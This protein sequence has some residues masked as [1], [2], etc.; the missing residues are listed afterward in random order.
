MSIAAPRTSMATAADL[1]ALSEDLRAEVVGGEIVQKA[2]PSFEHGDAQSALAALLK[3]PFQRGRGGPGGWWIAPEV[4]S[5]LE[6]YEVYLP[7]VAGW[8][9]DRVPER[10]KGRPIRV[11]PDWVAEVLSPT[12]ADRDLGPKLR[13]YHRGGVPHYWIIDAAHET[14]TVYRW[15]P[16]GYVVHLT[17]GRRDRVRAAPFE[18]LEFEV[19]LLFG[20]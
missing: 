1:A 4:E 17:A 16:E 12:T 10:P 11:R 18:E 9:R 5:E 8:R 7:D 19:A 13:A 15:S 20:G 14:L 2:A 6:T 3:P